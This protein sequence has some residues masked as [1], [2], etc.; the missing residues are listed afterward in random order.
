MRSFALALAL[1]LGSTCLARQAHATSCGSY[2]GQVYWPFDAYPVPTD[3]RPW[4]TTDCFTLSDYPFGD[5]SLRA[6]DHDVPVTLEL[7]GDDL[8]ATPEPYGVE[9]IVTFVPAE[10]LRPGRKYALTCENREPEAESWTFTTRENDDPAAPPEEVVI[11]S[12]VHTQGDDDGCC[13]GGDLLE[14]TFADYQAAYLAEGG[15][16]DILYP[17]GQIFPIVPSRSYETI[18]DIDAVLPP[19]GGPIDFTPVAADGERGPTTRLD[20]ESIRRQ[21]VYVPCAIAPRGFPLAL[22][23]LVP[24]VWMHAHRRRRRG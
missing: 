8:C 24:F 11:A 1:V 18:Y 22:W 4:M 9:S 7:D 5:C 2:P 17:D 3:F 13:G 21:A 14:L 19:V 20:P 23:L 6:H 10:P 12:A 15:R 16:I